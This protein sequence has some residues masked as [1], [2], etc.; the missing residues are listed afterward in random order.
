VYFLLD[1]VDEL[2]LSAIV[3]PDQ[4]KDP[5]GE[6]GFDPK[7]QA[8]PSAQ[9]L[10]MLLFYA[11]CVGMI[12]SRKIELAC[13]EDLTFRVHTGN[14]Q[15]GHS[16]VSEC[17]CHKLDALKGLFVQILRLCQKDGMVS[18]GHVALDGNR[19]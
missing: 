15:P 17:L 16:R 5:R 2:N 6:K 8:K 1:L 3:I 11:C 12:S 14:Q 10:T 4:S 7:M 9:R 19:R 18:L 13:H